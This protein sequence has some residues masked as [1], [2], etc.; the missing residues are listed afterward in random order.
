M[1]ESGGLLIRYRGICSY[2]G[3]ESLPLRQFI[4]AMRSELVRPLRHRRRWAECVE[5]FVAINN[6][7][8][9]YRRTSV[10]GE[11]IRRAAAIFFFLYYNKKQLA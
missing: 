11:G 5:T 2:R 7:L 1:V 8:T 6:L 9:T 4:S 10:C 3:F